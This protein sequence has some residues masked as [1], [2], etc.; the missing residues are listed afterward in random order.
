MLIQPSHEVSL[1][2]E[3]LIRKAIAIA[4]VRLKMPND[5]VIAEQYITLRKNAPV[6]YQV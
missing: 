6:S 2:N 3:Q 5:L 1:Q 4:T